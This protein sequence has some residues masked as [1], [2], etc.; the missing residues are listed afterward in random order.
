MYLYATVH[1]KVPR[2]IH[3]GVTKHAMR[4]R[5]VQ[6]QAKKYKRM[7]RSWN[8]LYVARVYVHY[9]LAAIMSGYSN[10]TIV[11]DTHQPGGPCTWVQAI[12]AYIIII[13]INYWST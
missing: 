12:L 6:G 5:H 4:S 8:A 13:C 7:Y 10:S 3:K 11:D 9:L 1:N 2:S